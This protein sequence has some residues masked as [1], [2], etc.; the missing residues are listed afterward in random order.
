[1]EDENK[2]KH[3]KEESHVTLIRIMGKDIPGDKT[4]FAG[5]T[6][7]PGIS[8]SFANAL[9]KSAGL[10]KKDKIQDIDKAK[11]EE[12]ENAVKNPKVPSFLKNRQKDFEGG[13]DKHIS[14]A[15]LKLRKEFDIKRIRKIR[16]YKGSRHAVGLPVRGQ[17]TKANF[18]RN[19]KPSVAAAKKNA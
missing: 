10:N 15:D 14:G 7:I 1:M 19:R 17:R 12:I 18:R 4:L 11:I 5:L 2:K 16:S 13:E 8:W 9:C 3:M 6:K